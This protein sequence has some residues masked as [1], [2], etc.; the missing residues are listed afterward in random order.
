M[1]GVSM[2]HERCSSRLFFLFATAVSPPIC[3]AHADSIHCA[4][5][6]PEQQ[7][8]A[9]ADDV[10]NFAADTKPGSIESSHA[11]PIAITDARAR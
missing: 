4:D 3:R 11:S 10:A 2:F 7:S 8:H 1:I 6:R 9:P 5:A